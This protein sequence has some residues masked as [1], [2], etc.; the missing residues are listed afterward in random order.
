MY[1]AATP[2]NEKVEEVA[3]QEV[4]TTIVFKDVDTYK[5]RFDKGIKK[6]DVFVYNI[7]GQLVN[8]SRNI[9]ASVDYI[10]PLK[11]NSSVYIV[12]VVGDNGQVVTKKIIK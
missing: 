9:D 8:T 10:V 1:W 2:N 12:K 6:A 4:N 5:V 3:K 11:G 7:S